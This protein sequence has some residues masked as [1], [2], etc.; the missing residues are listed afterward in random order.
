MWVAP[1]WAVM[2]GLTITAV[3]ATVRTAVIQ[4]HMRCHR[5]LLCP[6]RPAVCASLVVRSSGTG[7][8]C[9]IGGQRD[10]RPR[11]QA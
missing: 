7:G 6:M 11:D 8:S 9:R 10:A 5:D 3:A 1:A 4:G 2:V